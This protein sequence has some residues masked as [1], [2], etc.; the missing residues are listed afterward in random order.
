MQLST[1]LLADGAPARSIDAPFPA[2][3][4]AALDQLPQPLVEASGNPA[5]DGYGSPMASAA[6]VTAAR[7]LFPAASV[8]GDWVGGG[9]GGVGRH[10]YAVDVGG[11]PQHGLR[12]LPGSAMGGGHGAAA[13]QA[14]GGGHGAAG[15]QAA[16][17]GPALHSLL[18]SILE[19]AKLKMREEAGVMWGGGGDGVGGGFPQSQG[20]LAPGSA[21]GP[22][23]EADQRNARVQV[24][25]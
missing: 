24:V 15:G 6:T 16:G 12:A 19:I 7:T 17:G 22:D 3:P 23:R 5:R 2:S 20:P 1:L 10:T 25:E 18:D 14:A 4:A 21:T 9:G 13:G 11:L 8:P